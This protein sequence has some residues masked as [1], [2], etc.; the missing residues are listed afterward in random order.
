[1]SLPATLTALYQAFDDLPGIGRHAAK[2]LAHS[3]LFDVRGDTLTQ[4]V[5][6][7]RNSIQLCQSCR[8][9]TTET[10]CAHCQAERSASL[11]VIEQ[12]E[13]A[14]YWQQQGYRGYFFVLHGLLS[15]TSNI[16]PTE[17]GLKQL[18]GRAQSLELDTLELA[19]P[20]NSEGRLTQQFIRDFLA[21][22]G[23]AVSQRQRGEFL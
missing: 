7:A 5:S 16:G 10:V 8:A 17:L 18:L 21:P 9:Y 19:L 2:R 20:S 11:L 4:A 1:M 23:I 13:D 14:E 6:V 22:Y 12:G 3:V 15:P